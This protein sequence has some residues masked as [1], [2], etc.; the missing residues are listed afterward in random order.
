MF[1]PDTGH[2]TASFT[3]SSRRRQRTDSDGA[4]QSLR[5]RTKVAEHT[6]VHSPVDDDN[7]ADDSHDV[8]VASIERQQVPMAR[9][10]PVREKPSSIPLRSLKGDTGSYL[11]KTAYYSVK[12]LPAFPD[13]LRDAL[14]IDAKFVPSSQ[15]V[16]A[17]TPDTAYVW[18]YNSGPANLS[19]KVLPI[20]NSMKA[21]Q[22]PPLGHIIGSKTT[23]DL[24]LVL[25]APKSGKIMFW[26]NIDTLESQPLFQQRRH[27]LEGMVGSMAT[28]ERAVELIDAKHAG[29]LLRFNTGRIAQLLLRDGQGR[30]K[31]TVRPL[32]A[33][34]AG[35]GGWV[36]GFMNTFTASS[37]QAI[38]AKRVISTKG[39]AEVYACN[40]DGKFYFWD[41]DWTG[42]HLFKSA[43]ETKAEIQAGLIAGFDAPPGMFSALEIV[44]FAILNSPMSEKSALARPEESEP[45]THVLTLVRS[46]SESVTWFYLVE[47]MLERDAASTRRIIQVQ[48]NPQ[49]P[50]Q[51]GW[52]PKLLVP[53]PQHTAFIVY[54]TGVSI[55]SIISSENSPE[56][57]LLANGSTSR[58][59]F[60]DVLRFKL[61]DAHCF[62]A[63]EIEPPGTKT[64]NSTCLLMSR[65]AG[66]IRCTAN[67]PEKTD[68]PMNVHTLSPKGRIEQAVFFGGMSDNP[69]NFNNPNPFPQIYH[70]SEVEGAAITIS[71]EILS[72]TTPY[73]ERQTGAMEIFLAK[74]AKALRD[75]IEYTKRL[76]PNL[77]TITKWQLLWNA[78]KLASAQALWAKHEARKATMD[79]PTGTLL[80]S[81]AEDL[82]KEYHEEYAGLEDAGTV[83]DPVSSWFTRDLW[84]QERLF[85]S[86][87]QGLVNILHNYEREI[88]HKLKME[89]M[90]EADEIHW[91]LLETAMQFRTDHA[92]MYGIDDETIEDGVL[93]TGYEGLPRFWTSTQNSVTSIRHLVRLNNG[94]AKAATEVV[95][96]GEGDEYRETTETMLD[97]GYALTRY[98]L[99]VH[100]ERIRWCL[101]QE[102][103]KVRASGISLQQEFESKIRGQLIQELLEVD[104]GEAALDYAI[105][106]RDLESLVVVIHFNLEDYQSIIDDPKMHRRGKSE[107]SEHLQ[108]LRDRVK[109]KFFKIFGKPFSEA[110]LNSYVEAGR[111]WDLLEDDLVPDDIRTE[112][113]HSNEAFAKLSWMHDAASNDGTRNY[114]DAC[115]AL[116]KAA[117]SQETNAWCKDIQLCLAKLSLKAHESSTLDATLAQRNGDVKRLDAEIQA[118][119]MQ[120]VLYHVVQGAAHGAL[121]AESAVDLVMGEF[122]A[123][124]VAGKPALHQLLKRGFEE[125]LA[126]RVLAPEALVDVLTLMDTQPREDDVNGFLNFAFATALQVVPAAAAAPEALIE[127]IWKRCYIRDDWAAINRAAL[128]G[129]GDDD[130]LVQD[131]A[132]FYLCREIFSSTLK[133]NPYKTPVPLESALRSGSHESDLVNRFHREDLC[134]PIVQDNRVDDERLRA[135]IDGARLEHWRDVCLRV[136]EQ[137]GRQETEAEERGKKGTIGGMEWARRRGAL[138]GLEERLRREK[139][140]ERFPKVNGSS[141]SMEE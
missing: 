35:D 61:T 38:A 139:R 126:R 49:A 96:R 140:A 5:K 112:F 28:G 88:V 89:L 60:Q 10:M 64:R 116:A 85:T 100:L 110:Y 4:F 55:I 65:G 54:Q 108:S 17:T 7:G 14:D 128:A 72:S 40:K 8:P 95:V 121:D 62:F 46:Q 127:L 109:N 71:H 68:E 124:H 99:L 78:E 24:G 19:L 117:L 102:D 120:D 31:I 93:T 43:I 63:S 29:I 27:G 132:L 51:K 125:L 79:N 94:M 141:S 86:S 137:V 53:E 111:F 123:R 32:Y 34:G 21:Y 23:E 58:D 70:P 77:S 15:Y 52:P 47:L 6:D 42:Q 134:A 118:T 101:A 13:Q 9:P 97:A 131:T 37:Y 90:E 98:C 135:L 84:R 22:L 87:L 107:A 136:G 20:P 130:E 91:T 3:R 50:E 113:L 30:P 67:D 82:L 81:V 104:G 33:S 41:I 39:H 122:G 25:V 73:M 36:S 56:N 44:D 103:E 115:Q 133:D 138:E 106:F 16:L 119:W 48:F 69:I 11:T 66:I 2:R 1:S 75:L 114:K 80:Q 45:A 18:D 12:K 129:E 59:L 83:T 74:R 76:V 57:Q 26:E 105:E 92:A